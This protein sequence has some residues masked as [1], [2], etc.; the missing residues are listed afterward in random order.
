MKH[1]YT[2][3]MVIISATMLFMSGC[4][5]GNN[6]SILAVG[7]SSMQPIVEEAANNYRKVNPDVLVNVQGGGSGTGL[8]QIQTGA[9]S[10]GDSDVF[11]EE[12]D[13]IDP[14]KLKDHKIAVVGVVPIVNKDIK[15]KN[16]SSK[17]LQNIFAGRIDNWKEVG[18]PNVPITLVNRA[19][20]SGTRMVFEKVIM[21]GVYTKQAQEQDSTGMVRKIVSATP[22]AISY[23]AFP[24]VTKDVST[25]KL[26]GVSPTDENV[27]NNKWKIWS[28]EH[29]YTTK[30]PDK[31]VMKFIDYVKSS[32]FQKNTIKKMGY[33]P[34]DEMQVVKDFDGKVTAK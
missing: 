33:I 9:V 29:M 2:S 11:A 15:V 24:Y 25:V 6:D 14:S 34:I 31:N 3:A 5:K 12:K 17:D 10:I 32:K 19:S 1:I 26:D 22:G 16:L 7:S 21:Q 30:H 27:F 4:A 18:G 8:A 20:G 28:Y 23:I 13:G